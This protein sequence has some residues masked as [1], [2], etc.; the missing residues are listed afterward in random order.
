MQISPKSTHRLSKAVLLTRGEDDVAWTAALTPH[1]RAMGITW[2][3]ENASEGSLHYAD[4]AIVANPP[5]GALAEQPQLRLVASLWAGVDKLLSDPSLPSLPLLRSCDPGMQQSMGE[6]AAAHV[7]DAHLRLFQYREHQSQA[8]WKQLEVG[9]ASQ[10]KVLVLGAGYLGAHVAKLLKQLGFQVSSWSVSPHRELSNAGIASLYEA[11]S[12]PAAKG[13]ML[14]RVL[15]NELGK[16][17]IL[18]NLLPVT[19][20]T[21]GILNAQIFSACKPGL[22]L[23]NLAR[24]KHLVEL[25]L[26]EALNSK[27]IAHAWLDVF[28]TEPL[29]KDH[30][31]WSHPSVSVTPHV[32]GPS[33]YETVAQ[34]LCQDIKM[35]MQGET[36]QSL[37]QVSRGY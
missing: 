27:R 7:L 31:C 28:E 26:L 1:L 20:S 10:R 15:L 24:G 11:P 3:S 22:C 23:I 17:D 5:S 2:A 8:V 4:L 35:W 9:T 36:P 14:P 16:T 32:A 29:P 6:S 12:A 13:E 19:S 34:S 30:W 25:D 37:V 33:H 21:L 18:V